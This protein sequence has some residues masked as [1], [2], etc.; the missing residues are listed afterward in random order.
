LAER[1]HCSTATIRRDLH[2]LEA[3]SG[4]RRFHG[5]VAMEALAMESAFQE[6]LTVAD[7]EKRAIAVA[8]VAQLKAGQV[9]GLN[10]GTTTTQIA[11]HIAETGLDV[12]VVTNA[13]N[14]AFE[15][16]ASGISV[17]VV[18]GVLRPANYETTGPIALGA[19]ANLHLDWAVLGANGVDRRFGA[20]TFTEAEASVGRAVAE[21]ADRVVLAVDHSKLERTALFRMVDWDRIYAVAC[22]RAGAPT[23]SGWGVEP[24]EDAAEGAGFWRVHRHA[25]G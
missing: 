4:L 24:M 23:L 18:G 17:V 2:E 3:T 19:L 22:D 9:V 11:H 1:L 14:I 16:T 15:L 5:A 7:D 12:T 6:R 25:H 13:V 10:G 20:S 8:V 21:Q